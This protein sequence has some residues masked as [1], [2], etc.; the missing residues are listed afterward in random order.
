MIRIRRSKGSLGFGL[1]FIVICL[2]ILGVTT[3]KERYF[4]KSVL[5]IN[6][7]TTSRINDVKI[8]YANDNEIIE[9]GEI[10]RE[11]KYKHKI[12][13]KKTGAILLGYTGYNK[14]T[15]LYQVV[16]QI[17]PKMDRIEVILDDSR[18]PEKIKI[19]IGNK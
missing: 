10:K 6:N 8:I 2:I 1:I 18:N 3:V 7:K 13:T 17:T 5:A 16:S 12:N 11:S 9:V 15:Y 4:E 14:K 19:K